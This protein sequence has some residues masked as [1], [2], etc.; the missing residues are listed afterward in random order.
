MQGFYLSSIDLRKKLACR[1]AF[2]YSLE[3]YHPAENLLFVFCGGRDR[4]GG[5]GFRMACMFC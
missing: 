2:R 3:D 5:D 1:H 4:L